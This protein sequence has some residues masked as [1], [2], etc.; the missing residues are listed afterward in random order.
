MGLTKK[1]LRKKYKKELKKITDKIVKGYRPEK[2]IL[3]GSAVWGRMRR[4]S[5]LDL[6]IIKKGIGRKRRGERYLEVSKLLDHEIPVD[7]RIYTPYEVRKRLYL[8]DP[9]VK[10]IIKEGEIV[11]GT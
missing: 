5:D 10:K 8:G 6:F 9:F 3:F 7:L 1:Q 11:Y 2:I 4:D